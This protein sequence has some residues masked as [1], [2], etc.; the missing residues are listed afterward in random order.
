MRRSDRHDD[1][2]DNSLNNMR[3]QRQEP[4]SPKDLKQRWMTARSQRDEAQA[5]RDE[6]KRLKQELEQHAEQTHHLYVEEQK[7][8]Q[9]TLVLY[10]EE[11]SRYQT[12][13]TLYQD[14]KQLFETTLTAYQKKQREALTKS[15]EAEAQAQS[16]LELYNQETARTEDLL[17]NLQTAQGERDRYITLYEDAQSELKFERRSKAGIKGWETRRKK[18]NQRLKQEIGEM[19]LLLRD[20][21]ERRDSAIGNLEELAT[22]MDRI[23]TLVDSVDDSSTDTPI[24]LLQKFNRIVQAVRDILA[25]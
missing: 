4:A 6:L 24:G 5:E 19:T 17:L 3:S 12:T 11:H 22:R 25:E 15:R 7:K 23:Q 2:Y 21:L 10:E 18:E 13:L 8:S 14:E 1:S 16:Y 20:S 9:A